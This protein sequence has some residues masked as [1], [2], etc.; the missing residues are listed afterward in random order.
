MSPGFTLTAVLTLAL[1][2][3]ALTT[4]ATWTNAV[5]FNPW[6]QVRN[7]RSLRFISAT[8]LGSNGYSIHYDQVQYLRQQAHSFGDV[9]AFDL[10][11]LN[12]ALP[13][14]QPQAITAGIVSSN[15]FQTLGVKPEVGNFFQPDAN[16]RAYGSMDAIVLSDGL[17]RDR[18][19]ADPSV[20]GRPV[21]INR[22]VFTVVGVAPTEFAGI[23]GGLA[24]AAWV[25]LSATRD[26]SADAPPDPLLH[27]GLQIVVR[28]RP[29]VSDSTAKAE[30]HTLARSFALAQHNDSF[31]SWDLNIYDS[32]HFQRG[33]FSIIG[34]MLPVL[35]GASCLLMSLVC[36]N[37]A[38]LLA[39]HA[40]R[41]RREIAIRTAL[42]A[43]PSRIASQVFIEAGLLALAGALAGWAAS[44][45]ITRAVYVLMP[46][47]GF[48]L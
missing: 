18:F 1:G 33:F 43:R 24:E 47:L 31:N 45:G 37:V 44:V 19:N 3:G 4:V 13:N 22:H 40:A 9:A 8:V 21:S 23:F 25:P 2:I 26:L 38:S 29:G 11:T 15:Y 14:T 35:L 30:I 5:L 41:R 34:E 17:W 48:P 42:G 20:V 6:P 7:A 16:D 12:L 46:D 28:L 36:I 10:A 27:A 32:A 39:Q